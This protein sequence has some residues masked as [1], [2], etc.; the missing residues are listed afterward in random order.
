MQHLKFSLILGILCLVVFAG[1]KPVKREVQPAPPSATD[2]LVS[3]RWI[4]EACVIGNDCEAELAK[5]DEIVTALRAELPDKAEMLEKG[6][7]ELKAAPNHSRK[8]IATRYLPQF[9]DL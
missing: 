2:L 1:C 3:A 6:F 8:A 4:F 5:S 9:G 7:A